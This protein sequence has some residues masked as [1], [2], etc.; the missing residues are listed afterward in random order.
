M[1]ASVAS[2]TG[3]RARVTEAISALGLRVAKSQTNFLF[4]DVGLDSQK[5]FD[6]FLSQGIIVKPWKEKRYETFIRMTI[7]T[8]TENDRFIA[9]LQLLVAG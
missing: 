9:A 2:M 3:E 7:G 6:H 8:P 1:K 4:I 5:A